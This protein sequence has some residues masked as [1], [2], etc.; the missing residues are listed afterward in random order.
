MHYKNLCR[1]CMPSALDDFNSERVRHNINKFLCRGGK[2]SVLSRN[3]LT[4]V[5]PPIGQLLGSDG[6]L[7]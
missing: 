6:Y 1:K 4:V 7:T 3:L 2:K 5:L